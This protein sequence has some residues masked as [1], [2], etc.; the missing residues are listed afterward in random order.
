MEGQR[1]SRFDGT[2]G[3][4]SFIP[5][6]GWQ[7]AP[8]VGLMLAVA[9]LDIAD[10]E[11]YAGYSV[12]AAEDYLYNHGGT[13]P[14]GL[15]KEEIAAINLY[16]KQNLGNED[17]SFY[18]VLNRTFNDPDRR[19]LVP[20][21]LYLKLFFTG[22]KRLKNACVEGGVRLWRGFPNRRD[23]WQT[24]YAKG[25]LVY[26]WGFSS[27]TKDG[28][29]LHEARIHRGNQINPTSGRPRAVSTLP[30]EPGMP[31]RRSE[32]QEGQGLPNLADFP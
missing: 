21:F 27:T 8:L 22:V 20:F 1:S 30:H 31:A 24:E 25:S 2:G 26:W 4:R 13:D 14:H 16:T 5:F 23:D 7:Y 28:D 32:A 6:D 18:K 9:D 12:E 11:M 19:K 29:V 17:Q 10:V 15:K 3:K